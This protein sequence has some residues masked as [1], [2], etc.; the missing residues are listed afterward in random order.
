MGGNHTA[1]PSLDDVTTPSIDDVTSSAPRI[2]N[3]VTAVSQSQPPIHDSRGVRVGLKLGQ[4]VPQ[5]GQFWG[6]F[7]I[8]LSTF[9][10]T[11]PKCT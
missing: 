2:G 7:Q 5:M 10:R 11:A 9:W 8:S 6:L 3:D 1:T 4:I